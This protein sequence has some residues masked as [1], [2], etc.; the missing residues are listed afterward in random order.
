MI[1]LLLFLAYFK[2]TVCLLP[3]VMLPSLIR[4]KGDQYSS[5]MCAF[6]LCKASYKTADDFNVSNAVLLES[7]KR[8]KTI[9]LLFEDGIA[10]QHSL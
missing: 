3:E 4:H 7:S 1:I 10:S 5:A 2:E 8:N 6:M 9:H